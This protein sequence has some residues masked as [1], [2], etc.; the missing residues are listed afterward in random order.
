MP[1]G[2]K[3]GGRTKGTHNK[4]TVD[5]INRAESI[6]RIIETDYFED[7]IKKAT[8]AQ[9]LSLYSDMLEYVSPKL[10]RYD[11]RTTVSGKIILQIKRGQASND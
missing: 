7:D 10:G 4:K 3:Y 6:L 2:K 1:L 11:V 9:R 8:A 5:A